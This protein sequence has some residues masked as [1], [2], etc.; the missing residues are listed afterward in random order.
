MIEVR[1]IV[2]RPFKYDGVDYKTGDEWEPV[3]ARNDKAIIESDHYVR[4]E[5]VMKPKRR[6][7]KERM[8]E[9]AA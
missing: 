9:N 5:K 3:G 6:A 2:K 8:V 1:Y 7:S 4:V